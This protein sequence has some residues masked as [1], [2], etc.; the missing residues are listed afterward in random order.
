M[1]AWRTTT[2]T[3][4]KLSVPTILFLNT[5]SWQNKIQKRQ[6]EDKTRQKKTCFWLLKKGMVP[7]FPPRPRSSSMPTVKVCSSV[8]L[9]TWSNFT[10]NP[11]NSRKK[12]RLL[13][14]RCSFNA[15]RSGWMFP[16]CAAFSGFWLFLQVDLKQIFGLAPGLKM[17]DF[18]LSD[19]PLN[20]LN[21][22]IVLLEW[23]HTCGA[24]LLS[25]KCSARSFGNGLRCSAD[26]KSSKKYRFAQVC[27]TQLLNQ[28]VAQQQISY[29]VAGAPMPA[30]LFSVCVF[31]RCF[32]LFLPSMFLVLQGFFTAISML[33]YIQKTSTK[34]LLAVG[35]RSKQPIHQGFS[36]EKGF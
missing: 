18:T 32:G 36:S 14:T 7:T 33:F 27:S 30:P 21:S 12:R 23:Q 28:L 24:V 11:W 13:S 6:K 10:R 31:G 35:F 9:T 22:R 16:L 26:Q 1:L 5:N 15:K 2:P 3:C 34:R 29:S 19:L 17:S 25:K 4:R 20:F 8:P